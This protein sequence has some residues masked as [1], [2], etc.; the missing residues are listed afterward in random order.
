MGVK[1][2]VLLR[3]QGHVKE[4]VMVHVLLQTLVQAVLLVI[5]ELRA[6]QHVKAIVQR[7]IVADVI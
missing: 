7:V 3:V 6:M 1:E 4:I 5:V 2:A